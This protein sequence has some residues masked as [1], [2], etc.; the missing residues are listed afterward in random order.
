MINLAVRID[1]AI[2]HE[3]LLT[4][5]EEV[6]IVRFVTRRLGNAPGARHRHDRGRPA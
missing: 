2:H 4:S 5:R 3:E 6:G 1:D